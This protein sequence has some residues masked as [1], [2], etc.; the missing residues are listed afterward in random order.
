MKIPSF[1]QFP[2]PL[3]EK[4]KPLI[5][6]AAHMTLAETKVRYVGEPIALVIAESRAIAED[7]LDALRVDF[8]VLSAVMD[9]DSA[10]DTKSARIFDE[11]PDNIALDLHV[12][13]GDAE[14]AFGKAA[15][16]VREE[17]SIQRYSG[18]PL[19]GRSV[20]ALPNSV[21]GLTVWTTQQLPHFHRALVCRAL[22]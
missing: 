15:Q 5:R 22:G 16:V 11:F 3:I 1:G 2:K 21:G 12:Q 10:V 17:F 19:E 6:D 14:N 13:L 9:V 4:W 20:F 8:D 7:A 18:M